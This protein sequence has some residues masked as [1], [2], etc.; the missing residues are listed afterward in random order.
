[1]HLLVAQI[2]RCEL[3]ELQEVTPVWLKT[4]AA[5]QNCLAPS[6]LPEIFV[7]SNRPLCRALEVIAGKDGNNN[8]GHGVAKGKKHGS[9]EATMR[10]S[11]TGFLGLNEWH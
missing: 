11:V 8:E 1:M 6:V 9:A 5:E 4:C 3:C 7:P 2:R 10:I